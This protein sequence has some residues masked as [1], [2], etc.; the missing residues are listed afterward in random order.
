M[1]SSRS[2]SSGDQRRPATGGGDP[3]ENFRRRLETERRV[4]FAGIAAPR[5]PRRHRPRPTHRAPD[6]RAPP[7]SARIAA[8]DLEARFEPSGGSSWSFPDLQR[9]TE[10]IR[11]KLEMQGPRGRDG[12]PAAPAA[13][14]A[15]APGELD[16][17]AVSVYSDE[18]GGDYYD[19]PI[20]QDAVAEGPDGSVLVAIGDVT[21]RAPP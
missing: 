5:R 12:G 3:D 1:G 15:T 18:T 20:E 21:G 17:A 11:Q 14:R 19:F 4:A 7:T 10:E 16:I 9:M 6:P 2:S 8:G 13:D